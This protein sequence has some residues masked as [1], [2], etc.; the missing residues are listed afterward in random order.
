MKNRITTGLTLALLC[1]GAAHA[2]PFDGS[3][4]LL[5]A[6]ATVIEC[7]PLAGCHQVAAEAVAAPTFMRLDPTAKT[8]EATRGP[9]QKVSSKVEQWKTIDGKLILQGAEDGVDGV[10]DGVGWTIAIGH[11]SGRMV[12]TASGDDVAFTIFGSC[13]PM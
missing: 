2:S 8:L 4:P 3:K 7:L 6:T 11:D 5:C 12:L 1:T 9:E 13:M 10:R